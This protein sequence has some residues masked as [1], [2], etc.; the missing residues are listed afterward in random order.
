MIRLDQPPMT[1]NSKSKSARGNA[2][3]GWREMFR[4]DRHR[5]DPLLVFNMSI[6]NLAN[7]WDRAF[8]PLKAHENGT[9]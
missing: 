7:G 2:A 3:R 1:M 4:R 8:N 6:F 9:R 5:H